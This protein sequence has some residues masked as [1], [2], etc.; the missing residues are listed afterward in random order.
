ML[1]RVLIPIE[2]STHGSVAQE[3]GLRIAREQ[4]ASVTG[5][6]VV[7]M[8]SIA[9]GAGPIPPGGGAFVAELREGRVRDMEKGLDG[10]CERFLAQ[11]GAVGVTASVERVVGDP[12]ESIVAAAMFHDL[13]VMGQQSDFDFNGESDPSRRYVRAVLDNGICPVLILPAHMPQK[14][15]DRV[16]VAF[17]ASRPSARALQKLP[18]LPWIQE[19]YVT[20]LMADSSQEEA[21]PLL[22]RAADYLRAHG[23]NKVS[24]NWSRESI[25]DELSTERLQKYEL[26]VAGAHARSVFDFVV[27]S[28]AAHL[29]DQDERPVLI[30]G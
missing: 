17:N 24:T 14:R 30:C 21:E 20:L 3:I 1:K 23:I 26:V 13:V 12:A 10:L 22:A 19:A 16:L 2:P 8:P 7:D 27:G 29:I 11:A 28:V 4:R 18:M 15:P 6:A 5:L 9:R 25:I